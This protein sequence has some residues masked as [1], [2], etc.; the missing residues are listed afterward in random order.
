MPCGKFLM[1]SIEINTEG[2]TAIDDIKERKSKRLWRD[3]PAPKLTVISDK[4]QHSTF[5]TPKPPYKIRCLTEK[6]AWIPSMK[7]PPSRKLKLK[8]KSLKACDAKSPSSTSK[9]IYVDGTPYIKLEK[10]VVHLDKNSNEILSS[11]SLDQAHS[12]RLL[13]SDVDNKGI[14]DY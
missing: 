3:P 6:P 5:K 11:R 13:P 14:Q 9:V 2:T 1:R 7:Q 10:P 4:P 8:V 12:D